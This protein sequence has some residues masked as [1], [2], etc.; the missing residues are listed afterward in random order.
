MIGT[1]GGARLISTCDSTNS[2]G[3]PMTVRDGK[4]TYI[5]KYILPRCKAVGMKQRAKYVE[6]HHFSKHGDS[7]ILSLKEA[8]LLQ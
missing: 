6:K 3:F 1:F 5:F 2:Q 8:Y 7:L 4:T